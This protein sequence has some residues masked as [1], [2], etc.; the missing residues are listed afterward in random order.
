MLFE[1]YFYSPFSFS[2]HVAPRLPPLPTH[3]PT[4]FLLGYIHVPR[5]TLTRAR[6]E[7]NISLSLKITTTPPPPKMSIFDF[8]CFPLFLSLSVCYTPLPRPFVVPF[9]SVPF[10]LV[11]VIPGLVWGSNRVTSCRVDDLCANVRFVSALNGNKCDRGREGV[12]RIENIYQTMN[13]PP[14]VDVESAPAI[15]RSTVRNDV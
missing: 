9:R 2:D 7:N 1:I 8:R 5:S 4:I 6:T 12:A 14:H 15:S 3:P 13:E 11:S 10:R